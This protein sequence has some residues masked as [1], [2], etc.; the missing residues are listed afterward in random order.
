MTN[1][2]AGLTRWQYSNLALSDILKSDCSSHSKLRYPMSIL[3][4][5]DPA[6]LISMLVSPNCPTLE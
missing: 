1:M 4:I 6:A 3:S 5:L 2:K